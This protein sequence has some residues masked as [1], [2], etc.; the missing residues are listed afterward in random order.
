MARA[1]RKH[2]VT[3]NGKDYGAGDVISFTT[4][5]GTYYH[6]K[7]IE[8]IT[9]W[10]DGSSQIVIDDWPHGEKRIDVVDIDD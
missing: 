3:V 7:K 8:K 4:K 5:D 6:C 9:F 1:W 10:I 2:V